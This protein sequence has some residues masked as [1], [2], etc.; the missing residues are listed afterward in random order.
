PTIDLI[1]A[2]TSLNGIR[3]G[4]A[5]DLVVAAVAVDEVLS[6]VERDDHV[7]AVGAI[8]RRVRLRDDRRG[9]AETQRRG[10]LGAAAR[11]PGGEA[12][13]KRGRNASQHG[14]AEVAVL[15]VANR[16]RL[17]DVRL[18]GRED[19]AAASYPVDLPFPDVASVRNVDA[20]RR[21]ECA[22]TA[23][24]LPHDDAA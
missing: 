1:V 8:R 10:R 4:T 9:R 18:H 21:P 6:R 17:D 23:R 22:S 15:V 11:G 19:P 12:Q 14:S 20:D 24:V 16:P 2:R 3:A 5:T 13:N 7:R